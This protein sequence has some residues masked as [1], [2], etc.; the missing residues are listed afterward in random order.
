[1]NQGQKW[2]LFSQNDIYTHYG[3]ELI[4]NLRNT[5]FNIE[6]IIYPDGEN[7]K[8]LKVLEKDSPGR[9]SV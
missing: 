5:Q 7:A 1:M 9:S 3:D 2:V 6:L 8:S 4:K